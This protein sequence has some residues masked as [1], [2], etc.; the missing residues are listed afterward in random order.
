[1]SFGRRLAR[2][3]PDHAIDP[4][5]SADTAPGAGTD[6]LRTRCTRTGLSTTG[7]ALRSLGYRQ[8]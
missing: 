6:S 4:A 1:M 8:P 5:T 7:R 2:R 3:R